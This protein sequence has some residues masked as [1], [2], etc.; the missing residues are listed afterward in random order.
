L[1]EDKVDWFQPEHALTRSQDLTPAYH[2]A[3][4]FYF[5]NTAAFLNS[6]QLISSN[7]GGIVISELDAQDIDHEED[8]QIAEFKYRLRHA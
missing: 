1:Q 7:S 4:Q 6:S 3:G 5:F 8:W 2:D